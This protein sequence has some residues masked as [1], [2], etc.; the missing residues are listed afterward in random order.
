VLYPPSDWVSSTIPAE[1]SPPG[2]GQEHRRPAGPDGLPLHPYGLS[3][4]LCEAWLR[5]HDARWALTPG[6]IQPTYDEKREREHL[7]LRAGSDRDDIMMRAL[8]KIAGMDVPASLG[9]PVS[10]AAVPALLACPGCQQAQP[11][12]HSYCGH[13]G[14]PMRRLVPA[15]EIAAPAAASS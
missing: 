9:R 3:C 4:G 10:P 13:C 11:A 15:A 2:C 14:S 5:E 1:A 12:G 6:E 8:A 7:A